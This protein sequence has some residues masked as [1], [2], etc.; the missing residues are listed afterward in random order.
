VND[1]WLHRYRGWVC[2]AGFGFQLGLGVVTVVTSATVYLTLAVELLSGST[3]AGAAIGTVFG[4][5]RALPVLAAGRVRR[6]EQLRRL[7]R[8]LQAWGPASRRLAVGVQTA[9]AVLA[10]AALLRP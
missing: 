3:L 2:G 10:P 4:L 1:E 9:V 5:V 6:P 8:R 7:H